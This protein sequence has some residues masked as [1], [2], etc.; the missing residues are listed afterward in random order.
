MVMHVLT[1]IYGHALAYYHG[2]LY[3]HTTI[4]DHVCTYYHTIKHALPYM[5]MCVRTTIY[6]KVCT[7]YSI[8][9]VR[10]HYQ[11]WSCVL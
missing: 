8:R 1:T 2:W 4:Y 11:I 10:M 6:G 9:Y 5:V 3:M 7:H